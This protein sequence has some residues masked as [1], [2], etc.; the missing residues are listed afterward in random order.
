MHVDIRRCKSLRALGAFGPKNNLNMLKNFLEV[1]CV[2]GVCLIYKYVS[3]KFYARYMCVEYASNA[4]GARLRHASV[5]YMHVPIF[6]RYRFGS[7]PQACVRR[8]LNV[9]CAPVAR[10]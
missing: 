6:M 3:N 2:P 9:C 4:F 1:R 8:V 7:V 5:R 10:A